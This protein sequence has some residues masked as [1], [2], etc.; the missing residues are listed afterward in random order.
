[1]YNMSCTICNASNVSLPACACGT[2]ACRRCARRCVLDFTHSCACVG[3]QRPWSIDETLERIGKTFW[4]T[5]YRR[6]R[7]EHLRRRDET[8][9]AETSHEVERVRTERR[10]VAEM[11]VLADQI[12]RGNLSLLPKYRLLRETLHHAPQQ[13]RER[14][15]VLRR[16][17][18]AEC[19]GFLVEVAEEEEERVGTRFVC[20]TCNTQTCAR[21]GERTS[22]THRCDEEMVASRDAIRRE[23]KPCV[24]CHAPSAR[25]EGCPTMWCPHCHTFWNWDTERVI[26]ARGANPH[27]PDHRAYV[28]QRRH[29]RREVDDVPCGGLPD[30]IVVHTAFLRDSLAIN[31]LAVFAPI[32]I[33]ALECIH[34][35]QR[36]RHRY[37]VAWNPH[38]H[39]RAVRISYMLGDITAEVY[40]TTLERMERTFEYRREIGTVLE[41]L[42]LGSADIF[43]RFCGG[44]DD[45]V[46]ACIALN[47]LR[48][49]VDTRMVHLGQAFY[50]KPPRLESDWR[51]SGL[52]RVG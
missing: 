33:D 8:L 25:I 40:E 20:Q 49:L 21:C 27:N 37:P 50:R 29:A 18:E 36:M 26:D 51:W 31:H 42:V 10:L 39:F 41:T 17:A 46:N 38:E 32:M 30:G 48:D 52:R 19:P 22:E 4:N 7:R 34:L 11:R 12:R 47:S 13:H 45:V 23:C 35:S 16:C 43:Q 14:V 24:R 2:N 6:M 9:L 1:M 15:S 3:C 28:T 44:E 5:T